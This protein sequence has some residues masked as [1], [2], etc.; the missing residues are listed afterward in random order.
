MSDI[1]LLPFA[2]ASGAM[3]MARDEALLHS[4]AD[5]GIATLRFY[6]WDEPT[7]S[8][9][10]F[11]PAAERLPGMDWVRRSTGGA[12]I[13]HDP[14]H[15]IT[16]SLAL[17]PGPEWQPPDE[18]WLCRMHYFI[19]DVLKPMGVTA[20]AVVCGEEQK[21]GPVLCFHHHTPGDLVVEVDVEKPP[22]PGSSLRSRSDPS[23]AS[24]GEVAESCEA[25]P[26]GEG[27]IRSKIA[28]SAQR[29]WKGALLQHGSILLSR[30]PLAPQLPGIAELT[31]VTVERQRLTAAVV[32]HF[33]TQT[34][35]TIAPGNWTDDERRHAERNAV[36]KYTAAEWNEKR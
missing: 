32:E 31:G 11:Q 8:L 34:G 14:A 13:V 36:E 33:A 12:M 29:K 28:G 5:R 23:P 9:G 6:T 35:W 2:S 27:G 26:A 17:P 4:A 22:S 20:K 3:N 16:Y 24:G 10:Y 18:S 30:S 19:R 21:L 15:E 7:L 25:T 1:R